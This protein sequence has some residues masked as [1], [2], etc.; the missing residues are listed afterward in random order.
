MSGFAFLNMHTGFFKSVLSI[1]HFR[2]SQFIFSAPGC[3]VRQLQW[4]TQ[5][6]FG[7]KGGDKKINYFSKGKRFI[8]QKNKEMEVK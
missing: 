1:C 3:A 2:L 6:Q 8:D 7:G 4:Q 5:G